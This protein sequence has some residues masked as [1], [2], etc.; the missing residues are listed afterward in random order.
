MMHELGDATYWEDTDG[1]IDDEDAVSGLVEATGRVGEKYFSRQVYDAVQSDTFRRILFHTVKETYFPGE[2]RR[3]E[4]IHS[5]P[6]SAAKN[7][8]NFFQ[9]MADLGVM[10]RLKQGVYQY[11]YPMFP[12]YLRM[13]RRKREAKKPK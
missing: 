6:E 7:V 4:L 2:I 13:E 12:V 9:R 8:D 1:N 5:L 10:V 11:A 3:R